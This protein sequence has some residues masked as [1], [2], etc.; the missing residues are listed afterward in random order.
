[1]RFTNAASNPT[2]ATAYS[3]IATLATPVPVLSAVSSAAGGVTLTIGG[4]T[5]SYY[6]VYRSAD[7]T[8]F[9]YVGYTATT[10]YTDSGLASGTNYYYYVKSWNNGQLSNIVSVTTQ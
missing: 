2:G 5:S 6:M 3:N 7:G 9:S 8:N 10:S 4:T 1:M